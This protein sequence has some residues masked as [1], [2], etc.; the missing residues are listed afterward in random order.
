M[1]RDPSGVCVFF[2]LSCVCACVFPLSKRMKGTELKIGPEWL[3]QRS[4]SG[5][6]LAA[7]PAGDKARSASRPP[8][9]TAHLCEAR[10]G[11]EGL[12]SVDY[13]CC[14]WAPSCSPGSVFCTGRR[15]IRATSWLQDPITT[16]ETAAQRVKPMHHY[17]T[18]RT[19]LTQT[20]FP[21]MFLL[22][23]LSYKVV[24]WLCSTLHARF[25]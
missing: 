18:L 25:S 9:G 7:P 22:P 4:G 21:P 1:T 6:V 8:R 19:S 11:L 5:D 16:E 17:E 12:V 23:L 2:I 13:C 24:V 14:C 10:R 3:A 15:L 20:H